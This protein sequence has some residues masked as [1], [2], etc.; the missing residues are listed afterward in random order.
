MIGIGLITNLKNEPNFDEE[1]LTLAQKKDNN[2]KLERKISRTM[3]HKGI[4][5]KYDP[6][7]KIIENDVF[8]IWPD[9]PGNYTVS[10]TTDILTF[11]KPFFKEGKYGGTKVYF[12]GLDQLYEVKIRFQL[13]YMKPW[14][15]FPPMTPL[16]RNEW[17]EEFQRFPPPSLDLKW[18]FRWNDEEIEAIKK[19][20][21]SLDDPKFAEYLVNYKQYKRHNFILEL[22]RGK[23]TSPI[24]IN[25]A[26]IADGMVNGFNR[27]SKVECLKNVLREISPND[28]DFLRIY[29][30][31]SNEYFKSI[32][33]NKP[34]DDP[35]PEGCWVNR[36]HSAYF[37]TEMIK[38]DEKVSIECEPF[39]FMCKVQFRRGNF[40]VQFDM[41]GHDIPVYQAILKPIREEIDR[42]VCYPKTITPLSCKQARREY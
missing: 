18:L 21:R 34:P 3:T 31:K 8:L 2:L 19:K 32:L 42:Y 12:W 23:E 29:K 25:S 20:P 13:P 41:Y 37:S 24:S 11:P 40:H 4:P 15:P 30:E 33:K 6:Q 22:N 26:Q 7:V 14:N 9:Q 16:E 36:W 10:N 5:T 17:A 28:P 39:D 38:E 1:N 35:A 27:Y